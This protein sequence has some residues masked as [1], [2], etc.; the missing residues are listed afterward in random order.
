MHTAAYPCHKTAYGDCRY[1]TQ[2]VAAAPVAAAAAQKAGRIG[3][4]WPYRRALHITF[5]TVDET[6]QEVNEVEAEARAR[7]GWVR[8]PHISQSLTF[9]PDLWTR[10]CHRMP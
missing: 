8:A 7:V 10:R 3:T 1:T 9:K 4:R 2:R 6:K 5:A